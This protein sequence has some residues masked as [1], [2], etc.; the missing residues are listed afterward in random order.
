MKITSVGRF[1][2][3]LGPKLIPNGDRRRL[4]CDVFIVGTLTDDDYDGSGDDDNDDDDD[5][6]D[7][8]KLEEK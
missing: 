3:T 8:N 5:D 2:V 1:G 6:G 7:G 4:V